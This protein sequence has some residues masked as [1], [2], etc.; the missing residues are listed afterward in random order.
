MWLEIGCDGSIKNQFGQDPRRGGVSENRRAGGSNGC[1]G[2][3]LAG[4]CT[5]LAGL[6]DEFK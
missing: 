4:P 5:T 2:M 3:D 1:A 6:K